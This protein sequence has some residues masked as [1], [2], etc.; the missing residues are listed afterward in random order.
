MLVNKLRKVIDSHTDRQ[1]KGSNISNYNT[2][3]NA[4]IMSL[5]L[6]NNEDTRLNSCSDS[7]NDKGYISIFNLF[8]SD[9]RI[10]CP[11]CYLMLLAIGTSIGIIMSYRRNICPFFVISERGM[12]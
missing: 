10:Y 1:S 4:S 3:S 6:I 2:V 11:V 12:I 5:D 8:K 7:Q 9:T